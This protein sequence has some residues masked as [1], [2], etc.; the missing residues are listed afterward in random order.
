MDYG[1]LIEWCVMMDLL[2][3]VKDL[4]I[5]LVVMNDFYY[6]Y[7]YEVDVYEVLLCVQLGL[8]MDDLNCFKFDGDG[9]YIKI[10]VEMWQFFC[11]YLE[12]CDNMLLIVECCE[13]E[14]NILVNYMFW[15]LVFEGEIED[16]W[17]IKEVEVGLYYWYLGGILDKVCKQVEYE[18]GIILQM[19]FFGYFFVVVD[20][21]NWVK[22]NGI[23]VGFGCGFGVG[24][25][26][27]YVMCIIDFDLFEYGLIFEWFFNFDC[28]LMFDFDVDFDDCCCG[29]V[30][31]YVIEKYGFECVVQIVIYGM[32]KFKQVFKDVGC[33][34][35]FL[36]SMGEWL[37]K[38]MLLFVMGKDMLF[39][40]MFDLVYF[41]YKEVSEFWVLIEMDF[42]VKMVFDCVFGFEG[43]KC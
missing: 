40:G 14:F 34:F 1:F 6:I 24:L 8:M 27:V 10:V 43:L 41:C 5:L 22:D 9:Y 35:G 36:F 15:F 2:C 32:I 13:V 19:G 11:D 26:V 7:Q 21:I 31:D 29:E 23:C 17:L 12:V 28:V 18:I 42:E 3:F 30:I 33:V 20:F 25:M 16:S 39:D 4:S 37:I 38:V